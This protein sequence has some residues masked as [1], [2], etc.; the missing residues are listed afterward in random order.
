MSDEFNVCVVLTRD[1]GQ[2]YV[3]HSNSPHQLEACQVYVSS[4][5]LIE[6]TK[7]TNSDDPKD[8]AIIVQQ[9]PDEI[10]RAIA[11]GK[12]LSYSRMDLKGSPTVAARIE[13]QIAEG[14]QKAD[15]PT[16]STGASVPAVEAVAVEETIE[17]GAWC[18]GTTQEFFP[19]A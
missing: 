1:D 13:R 5:T 14:V 6:G 15:Q 18:V 19:N 7:I 10:K 16:T 2:G 12:S 11:Q 9:T 3:L 4:G 8:K 17:P